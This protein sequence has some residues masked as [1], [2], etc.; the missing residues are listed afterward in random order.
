[1]RLLASSKRR[2]GKTQNLRENNGSRVILELGDRKQGGGEGQRMEK[3][4]Q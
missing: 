3:K 4:D 1:M 2:K